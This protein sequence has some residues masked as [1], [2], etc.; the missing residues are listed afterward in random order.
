MTMEEEPTLKQLIEN[1]DVAAVERYLEN[2]GDPNADCGRGKSALMYALLVSD[3]NR[4]DI[5]PMLIAKGANVFGTDDRGRTTLIYALQTPLPFV[6]EKLIVCGCDAHAVDKSGNS[7]L[8]YAIRNNRVKIAK[9]LMSM[10]VNVNQANNDGMTPLHIACELGKHNLVSDLLEYGAD[11]NAQDITGKT[12]VMISLNKRDASCTAILRVHG[13]DASLKTFNGKSYFDIAVEKRM[14]TDLF[15][16]VKYTDLPDLL[17]KDCRGSKF[18][19]ELSWNNAVFTKVIKKDVMGTLQESS[20][21]HPLFAALWSNNFDAAEIILARGFDASRTDS[22]GR[23]ALAYYIQTYV[24]RL[25]SER[26]LDVDI[27]EALIANGAISKTNG[28]DL[29]K[30]RDDFG[31]DEVFVILASA[32]AKVES[33]ESLTRMKHVCYLTAAR[34]Q[35]EAVIIASRITWLLDPNSPLPLE[36]AIDLLA[37]NFGH[38][39]IIRSH[40]SMNSMPFLTREEVKVRAVRLLKDLAAIRRNKNQ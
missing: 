21:V 9:T 39:L 36:T 24:D 5:V 37:E 25:G 30:F 14:I 33:G 4:K 1:N 18:W 31:V 26:A 12:P 38:R 15:Y 20:G 6:C 11:I 29:D 7:A 16:L 8:H 35:E 3:K 17:P 13:Y 34:M 28:R 10:G 27:I 23:T 19:K 2:G 40:I 22:K 32:R